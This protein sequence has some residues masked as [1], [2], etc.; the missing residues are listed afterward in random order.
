MILQ[1]VTPTLSKRG[2]AP[3]TACC[4]PPS[5]LRVDAQRPSIEPVRVVGHLAPAPGDSAAAG[6]TLSWACGRRRAQKGAAGARCCLSMHQPIIKSFRN[7]QT[8]LGLPNRSCPVV[9]PC[10][11]TP[12]VAVLTAIPDHACLALCLPAPAAPSAWAGTKWSALKA[13][14]APAWWVAGLT[15]RP[16]PQVF[17]RLA[18]L[19]GGSACAC[20]R[21]VADAYRMG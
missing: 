12:P 10:F 15:A 17:H 2:K 6:E 14:A 9:P 7:G 18:S 16:L 11:H 1:C 4:A 8:A 5:K 3:T 13:H 20:C 21:L 19:P